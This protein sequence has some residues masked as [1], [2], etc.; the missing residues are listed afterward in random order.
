MLQLRLIVNKDLVNPVAKQFTGCGGDIGAHKQ[1]VNR[2]I[3][4][5]GQFPGLADQLKGDR[6]NHS[7]NMI[8]IDGNAFVQA[9]VDGDLFIFFEFQHAGWSV[10][11]THLAHFT[12]G[13]DF[14]S[15]V[16]I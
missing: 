15:S 14:Q 10:F 13:G 7:F 4:D 16:Y 1:G 5:G 9:F 11:Q 8:D 6:M 3:D 12:G 2:M